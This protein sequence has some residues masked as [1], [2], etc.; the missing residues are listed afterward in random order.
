[1]KERR[2]TEGRD[3][4]ENQPR[5]IAACSREELEGSEDDLTMGG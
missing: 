4:D 2:R 1:M 5:S 3:V